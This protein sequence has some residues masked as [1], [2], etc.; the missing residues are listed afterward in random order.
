MVSDYIFFE[1][2]FIQ[3]VHIMIKNTKPKPVHV[4]C[5][6]SIGR[7]ELFRIIH[8]GKQDNNHLA[9]FYNVM[10]LWK[11]IFSGIINFQGM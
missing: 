2:I 10:I 6:I 5:K 1:N 11:D 4:S 7:L 8:T 3:Y 9:G